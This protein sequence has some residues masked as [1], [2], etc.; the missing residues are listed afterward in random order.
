MLARVYP[1]LLLCIVHSVQSTN[2]TC[3]GY[4][5][6]CSKL[7]SNVTFLGAHNS[8]AVG[9]GISDNQYYDVTVQLDDGVRLLQGQGHNGTNKEG[10]T[11]E[12][13]H[14]SCALQDGGT[15]EKFLTKVKDW[16]VLNPT[17]VITILWVNS[18][19]V[20]ATS[21]AKAY[22]SSG[23]SNYSYAPTADKVTTWPTMQSL[24]SAGTTVV[25]FITSEEDHT[26]VPYLLG[27]WTNIWETPYENTN[28]KNFTCGLDRGTRPNTLY[29]ANHF[30]YEEQDIVGI[31][32]D[33]PD[34]D[35]ISK[36]NAKD[37][38]L[39]H[40]DLCASL[41][42]RFPN[43]FLVDYYSAASGGAL[44]AVAEMNN[45]TY[46]TKTLGDGTTISAIAKFF[47]GENE[48]RNI[49]IVASVGAAVLIGCWVGACIFFRRKAKRQAL[50]TEDELFIK[51]TP[52]DSFGFLAVP[53]T[54]TNRL[55]Q[56]PK[57]DPL[58][59]EHEM[60]MPAKLE[61]LSSHSRAESFNSVGSGTTLASNSA[62]DNIRGQGRP[63]PSIPVN[64]PSPP[65]SSYVDMRDGTNMTSSNTRHGIW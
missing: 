38:V 44:Q 51:P 41:N 31:S 20:P 23:L 43:F 55:S 39:E 54:F 19:S 14:S 3:N 49:A 42:S 26:A 65:Y 37:Y 52:S 29:L 17:E 59:E 24:I 4:S 22:V 15:L 28:W 53:R 56:Q 50:A 62:F 57:Y 13:C 6:L 64:G 21:W 46:V 11:I 61:P 58:S 45:V 16:V 2:T 35:D 32:I 36:T 40:G 7:Y 1:W 27:E 18:D 9:T 30:A 8:Y 34:T 33:T 25:N 47:G 60:L 5:S 48:I 10:S 12:L 63:L